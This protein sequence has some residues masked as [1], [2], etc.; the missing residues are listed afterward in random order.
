MI[1]AA[2]GK[3]DIEMGKKG[4][5]RTAGWKRSKS[6]STEWIEVS[7]IEGDHIA[8]FSAWNLFFRRC[9][10]VI[11]KYPSAKENFRQYSLI[12]IGRY[13]HLTFI[14]SSMQSMRLFELLFS[15][16]IKLLS[17]IGV[18]DPHSD[19]TNDET[20]AMNRKKRHSTS[21][22]IALRRI[23]GR[24]DPRRTGD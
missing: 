14:Q 15:K 4:R 16:Y 11:R 22:C 7:K 1:A 12:Q 23:S 24:W 9:P 2:K 3:R 8:S 20:E 6:S 21:S 17:V 19:D 13:R 10:F 5:T 18:G